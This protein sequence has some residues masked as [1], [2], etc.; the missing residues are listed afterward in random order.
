MFKQI[1]SLPAEP[2]ALKKWLAEAARDGGLP[3]ARANSPQLTIT[4][5]WTDRKPS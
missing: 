1:E 3:P 2:G 5:S 4:A